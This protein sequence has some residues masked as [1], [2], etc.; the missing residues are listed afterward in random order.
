MREKLDDPAYSGWF[1][2]FDT[3]KTSYHVPL[4]A[5]E[6]TSKCSPFYH[7]QEQTPEVPTTLQPHP[8]GS[9]A[10]GQCD[11]GDSP[12]G[13]YL[14]DHRNGSMLRDWIVSEHINGPTGVGDPAIDGL[15][16]DDYWCSDLI[17]RRDPHVAG[18]PCG[19]PVQGPTEI[20][21]HSQV[22]MGL[23]DDDIANITVEWNMT[24]TAVQRGILAKGGYTWSLI[25][26]QGNA[27]A[28]PTKLDRA[29][30]VQQMREACNSASEWQRFPMLFGVTVC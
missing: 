7:D 29:T 10:G 2:R 27:N 19:D 5:P 26:G 30:C 9:C 16:I 15:F 28:S 17:C 3:R 13:E 20:D 1:L 11:C 22:D 14:F 6:N 21:R 25:K 18:C 8:D 4:C 24:M 23:T 12:C